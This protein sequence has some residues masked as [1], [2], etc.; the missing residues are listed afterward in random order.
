MQ[1]PSN[2]WLRRKIAEDP[3]EPSGCVSC[4]A[5][6]GACANY[7]NCPGNPS[8]SLERLRAELLEFVPQCLEKRGD[9]YYPTHA[10][11]I[12]LMEW[13]AERGVNAQ[14]SITDGERFSID[15]LEGARP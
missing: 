11:C 3:D 8:W 1:L 13:L 7:P 6:A 15:G 14:V 12:R 5:I 2:D 10:G 9:R 4:G